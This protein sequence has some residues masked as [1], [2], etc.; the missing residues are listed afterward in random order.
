MF[1]SW[2]SFVTGSIAECEMRR[3]SRVQAFKMIFER[4]FTE[5]PVDD[6]LWSELGEKDVEFARQI[7]STYQQNKAAIEDKISKLLVGYS[8]DRVHKIDLALLCEALTEIDYLK[9]PAPVVINEVVEIA[10]LYSTSDS[11]KF[12][13]GVLSSALKGE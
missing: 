11:P 4:F 8:I 2:K 7:F 1:T 6:E 3:N 13:N 9:I 10:K 5:Q 12:I